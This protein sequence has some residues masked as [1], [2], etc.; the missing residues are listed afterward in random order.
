MFS[1]TQLGFYSQTNTLRMFPVQNLT[2][3]LQ[4]FTY[5]VFS[6]IQDDNERLKT[7][8][9]KI[10]TLVFFVVTPIMLFLVVIAEPMFRFVLTKK[11]LPAASYFQILAIS[12]IVYPLSIYNLNFVFAKGRS[13]L[14]LE[15]VLIKK[16]SSIMFLLLIIPYSIWGAIYAQSI[17]MLFHAFVNAI[18]CGKQINYPVHNQIIDI[19]PIFI[20]CCVITI[21]T[22]YIDILFFS[23][24]LESDLII[25]I[26][27]FIFYFTLYLI[28]SKLLRI[29]GLIELINIGNQVI[30]KTKNK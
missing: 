25:I 17:S 26:L 10:T 29:K 7:I 12:A 9:R 28:Y 4:K 24:Y 15:M 2:T 18:F 8:F 19:L 13:D 23:K 22:Y 21:L 3:A 20:F 1:A 6:I 11:W 27:D 30:L 16:L 5:P 14:H